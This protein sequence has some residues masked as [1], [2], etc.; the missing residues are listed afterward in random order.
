[1]FEFVYKMFGEGY[2]T[3]PKQGIG[4]IP[5]QLK[6]KLNHTEFRFNSPVVEVTNQAIVMASGETIPHTGVIVASNTPSV[7]KQPNNKKKQWKGCMCLYFEVDQTNLP[8]ET[9][10]LIADKNRYAN[11]LYAF[12]DYASKQLILS[13]TTLKYSSLTEAEL[14][15]IITSEVKHYTGAQTVNF[16]KQDTINYALPDLASVKQTVPLSELQLESN[17]I[18]AGDSLLNGSLNAAMASGQLA[19][20][21]LLKNNL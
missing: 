16:I 1:M 5:K 6:S 17:I 9:I 20:K 21:A 3:I 19:V 18:L 13:V 4:E 10:G 15:T 14:I 12:T 7:I 2:A 11:N 8:D